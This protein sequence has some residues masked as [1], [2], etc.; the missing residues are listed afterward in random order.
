[1]TLRIGGSADN[2]FRGGLG[3]ARRGRHT[4]RTN[5]QTDKQ[6]IDGKTYNSFRGDNINSFDLSEREPN[7]ERLLQV[8]PVPP[9][10]PA[11]S[12]HVPTPA[13]R[14]ARVFGALGALGGRCGGANAVPLSIRA[15]PVA[16]A[17]AHQRA[18]ARPSRREA[19]PTRLAPRYS[20]RVGALRVLGAYGG[21]GGYCYYFGTPSAQGYFHSAASMNYIRSLI[22]TGFGDLRQVGVGE[23]GEGRLCHSR[24]L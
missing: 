6:V 4:Y 22:D 24:V 5:K 18:A 13:P 19:R 16:R 23:R 7:P 8:G 21:A 12:A 2:T 17:C 15:R 9:R 14:R 20:A 10:A 1:M 3:N 11:G